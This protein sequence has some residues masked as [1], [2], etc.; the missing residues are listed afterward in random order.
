MPPPVQ[1]ATALAPAGYMHLLLL[2]FVQIF[3]SIRHQWIKEAADGNQVARMRE[4]KSG[5]L[6]RSSPG[7]VGSVSTVAAPEL[8]AALRAL[9]DRNRRA[10]LS[11]VRDRPRAVGEVADA[12]S[13]SQQTVSHHLR[14]LRDAGLVTE[15]HEGTRHLFVVRPEGFQVV[16]AFL[17]DFWPARLVALKAAAEAA[18][19]DGRHG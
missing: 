18:I 9:A 14:A 19:R 4:V 16:D 7:G 5:R 11:E 2:I 13:M 3:I 1:K 12:V 6:R 8:D 10:I 15:E 17:S